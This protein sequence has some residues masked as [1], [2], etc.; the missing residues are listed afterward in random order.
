ME[1]VLKVFCGNGDF[2]VEKAASQ[3]MASWKKEQ[4]GEVD[5]EVLEA[6]VGNLEQLENC[7][8]QFYLA[9]RSLPLWGQAKCLHL[10]GANFVSESSTFRSE[11][12]KKKMEAW[13]EFLAN[14]LK[15]G[16]GNLPLC[17][18]VTL[19]PIDRRRGEYRW[20]K[21]RG[22]LTDMGS[23]CVVDEEGVRKQAEDLGISLGPQAA[24]VLS[25]RV[26]SAPGVLHMELEKLSTYLGEGET[27]QK[28]TVLNMVPPFGE[29]DFFEAVEAF[30]H[31][32]LPWALEALSRQF[33]TDAYAGRPVLT[34]LQNRLRLMTQA[35][36]LLDLESSKSVWNNK[37]FESLAT[38]YQSLFG[39]ADTKS[40]FNLFTQN[41]WYLSHKIVP[42]S[43][44]R[45]LKK[46]MDCQVA[47]AR[48]FE[49]ML[50]NPNEHLEVLQQLF[51][52]CLS[53]TG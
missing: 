32:D 33:F 1:V 47:S 29:V 45:P 38:R 24:E 22:V 2:V 21:A 19:Y 31:F 30:F 18:L 10:K 7:L 23:S 3:F 13:L 37:F 48:C 42:I 4:R 14:Y 16:V 5:E 36:V 39:E 44:Q 26:G 28:S 53:T 15:E 11:S 35:R 9:A 34:S 41:S 12:A 25:D 6:A 40:V 51:I 50:E 17:L 52:E 27:L 43:R 49:K 8:R 20:F 46:W